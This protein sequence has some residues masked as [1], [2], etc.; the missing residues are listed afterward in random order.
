MH[1]I[2]HLLIFLILWAIIYYN[3]ENDL[4]ECKCIDILKE[5]NDQSYEYNLI[6]DH[7]KDSIRCNITFS[8]YVLRYGEGKYC[9]HKLSDYG[10]Y[11]NEIL[12]L[13]EF[14]QKNRSKKT[15]SRN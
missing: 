2:G 11:D 13:K 7:I 1:L 9:A 14:L 15:I 4:G 3:L 8:E 10:Y 5:Y 6:Q 12:K